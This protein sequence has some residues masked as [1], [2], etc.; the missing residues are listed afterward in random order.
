M[1]LK[2][3]VVDGC[4]H[5]LLKRRPGQAKRAKIKR[6]LKIQNALNPKRIEIL[7]SVFLRLKP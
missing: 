4:M 3:L 1:M 5:S 6:R 7:T 2:L